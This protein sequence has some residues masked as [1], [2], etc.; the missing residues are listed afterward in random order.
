M[1]FFLLID[2]VGSY[3]VGKTLGNGTFGKVKLGTHVSTKENVAIKFIK[4]NKLSIKQKETCLREIDIMKL[5]DHPNIVKLL[6]VVDKKEEES[7][8]YLIVEYVSGGELFDYI[9][10]REYIKEKEAR[11]FFRQIISAIEYCHANLIVHR[12][13]KPENLLLDS[14]GNIKI[15]DFGL[16]NNMQPGKLMESFCGSPLYAAPEILKAEK[17]LGPPVDIW[18]LGVI[19][20]AVMCGNLPWEGDS[21]AEISYHSVHGHYEDPTHLSREAV[22]ILRRMIN[23]NPKERATIQE[24]KNHPWTNIDYDEIPKS[25]LPPREPVYEIKEDIYNHLVS[26]GFQ[27][28]KETR[29]TILR[30]ENCGIVNVYHLL[31]DRFADKEVE[32][33]KSKLDILKPKKLLLDKKIPSSNSLAS[34]PED[35]TSSIDTDSFKTESRG[36]NATS[37]E[38]GSPSSFIKEIHLK[39]LDVD[40]EDLEESLDNQQLPRRQSDPNQETKHELS[41][42]PTLL[43]SLSAPFQISPQSPS[44][45]FKPS[46]VAQASV[47]Q[48]SSP[49]RKTNIVNGS[50][51]DKPLY[52]QSNWISQQQQEE[53]N[54]Q[55]QQQQLLLQQQQQQSQQHRRYSIGVSSIPNTL[56]EEDEDH[57]QQYSQQERDLAMNEMRDTIHQ[58]KKTSA[59]EGSSALYECPLFPSALNSLINNNNNNTNNNN[60]PLRSTLVDINTFLSNGV[61]NQPVVEAPKTNRRMSLDS[62]MHGGNPNDVIEKNEH[63]ASPRTSKGGVF[64][65]STTTNKS[66]EKTIVEVKRSLK[67]SGFFTKKKGPY[68]FLCY[69]DENAV[70][71]Q[72]EIVKI[73]NLDLTGIQLKRISGDTWK[74]KDICTNLVNS[75]NL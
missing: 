17:Y 15:S 63:L 27:N 65:S 47:Q 69:D 22:N 53:L 21:Q 3:E 71:F 19:M 20:Y 55:Q 16:S 72:I 36:S 68:V 9:V 4:N 70:K 59:I 25:F 7:T 32:K 35:D 57:Q 12:D 34:I 8:T 62:R 30:N 67:E 46:S 26:L 6:D 1:P 49:R 33:L 29:D 75:I 5:L 23:P 42:I 18:S 64:K 52:Y 13:L 39:D 43:S 51:A 50:S 31:L 56:M 74:Y 24:L 60:N 37:V 28:S 40:F 66:P 11:K 41:K 61:T 44:A 14:N 58:L 48:Q 54:Q 38:G 2:H 73:S 45:S 10:A